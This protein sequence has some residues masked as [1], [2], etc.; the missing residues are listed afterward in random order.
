[1]TN[2]LVLVFSALLAGFPRRKITT[3]DEE[4]P[5]DL[6]DRNGVFFYDSAEMPQRESRHFGGSWNIHK[7]FGFLCGL[8]NR[9][10]KHVLIPPLSE[11][12]THVGCQFL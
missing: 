10:A 6:N 11:W 8:V 4:L 5:A 3:Q 2:Q 1:M 12:V 7:H 9:L